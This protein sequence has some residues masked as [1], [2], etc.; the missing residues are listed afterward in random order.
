MWTYVLYGTVVDVSITELRANL[1][2][3]LARVRAGEEITI[4]D[5]GK[6]VA[7]LVPAEQEDRLAALEA[8]GIIGP[9]PTGPPWIPEDHPLI[10]VDGDKAVS[11]YISEMR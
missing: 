9:A 3:N 5:H 2:A 7:R 1:A 6:P 4:T 8:A 11:D 10:Q